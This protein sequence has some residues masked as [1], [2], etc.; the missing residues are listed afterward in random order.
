MLRE[1]GNDLLEG[2]RAAKKIERACK[3]EVDPALAC[4]SE[5]VDVFEGHDAAAVRHGH[6]RMR[7]EKVHQGKVRPRVALRSVEAMNVKGAAEEGECFDRF[8][9]EHHRGRGEESVRD[10]MVRRR[11]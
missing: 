2:E 8:A 3:Y 9:V 7:H 1:V 6:G 11:G 5:R 4:L 10:E